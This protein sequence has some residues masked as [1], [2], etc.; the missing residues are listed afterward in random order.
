MFAW[1]LFILELHCISPVNAR[2]KFMS[3]LFITLFHIILKVHFWLEHLKCFSLSTT[4][5]F[6]FQNVQPMIDWCIHFSVSD[7]GILRKRNDWLLAWQL[8][9]KAEPLWANSVQ[10]N[11]TF[12]ATNKSYKNFKIIQISLRWSAVYVG[13]YVRKQ[14]RKWRT[15]LAF[16]FFCLTGHARHAKI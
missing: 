10:C 16:F 14:V 7:T 11:A 9:S 3:V 8:N 5:F 12:G 1:L 13:R 6:S 15:R 2:F 4:Y